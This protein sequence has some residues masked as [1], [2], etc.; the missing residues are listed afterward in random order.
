MIIE[1]NLSKYIVFSED[2]LLNAL[3]KISENKSRLVFSVS[4]TGELEGMLT[5]GD[6]RRWLSRATRSTDVQ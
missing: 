4:E 2:N 1:R 3:R 6:F 5:D